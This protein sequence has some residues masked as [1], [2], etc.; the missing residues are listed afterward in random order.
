MRRRKKMIDTV[1][2]TIEGKRCLPIEN[3][4]I[5]SRWFLHSKSGRYEK[6]VINETAAQKHDG[7]YRPRVRTIKRAGIIYR[8]IEFSVPKLLHGNNVDEVSDEDFD[9]VV[10]TLKERLEDFKIITTIDALKSAAVSSFHPSKNIVLS[11]GYTSQAVIKELSKVNLTKRMDL[12][13]DSFRNDGHSLQY[14]TNSHSFVIYD[15]IQDLKKPKKR[16]IDKDQTLRQLSLFDDIQKKERKE[17]LRFE[18]RLSRK[19]KVNSIMDKMGYSKNPT[20]KDIFSKKVC[21]E[22]LMMYWQELIAE[23]NLFLFSISSSPKQTFEKIRKYYLSIKPKEIVYLVGLQQLC[24]DGNGIR[25]LRNLVEKKASTRTWYRFSDDM[26]KLNDMQ[27]ISGCHGWVNQ[28][29][30]QL[31][32]FDSLKVYD[33]L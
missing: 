11:G 21:Q 15:K 13:R 19:V 29:K 27:K 16:A 7:I 12:N 5:P 14:Y 32:D 25:D 4:N 18:V 2:L 26:K 31:N 28:I 17:I 10:D 33:D 24:Q 8:Q 1:I 20:F 3:P 23:K 30:K 9:I 6:H 22:V